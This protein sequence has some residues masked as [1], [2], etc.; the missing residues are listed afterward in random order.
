MSLFRAPYVSPY[1]G[2]LEESETSEERRPLN[3]AKR[4][5]RHFDFLA[6][7]AHA[8]GITMMSL[9]CKGCLDASD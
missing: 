1:Y 8:F 7:F 6:V 9:A 4:T 5:F 2:T 3:E